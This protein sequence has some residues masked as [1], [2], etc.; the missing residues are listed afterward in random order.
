MENLTNNRVDLVNKKNIH[1]KQGNKYL[2]IAL[3]LCVA[4]ITLTVFLGSYNLISTI[5]IG[6]GWTFIFLHLGEHFKKG[7]VKREIDNIEIINFL[8]D[9]VTPVPD[10][11]NE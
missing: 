4:A 6:I 11:E 7:K 2:V 3:I 9:P 8:H 10:T 5:L 1:E